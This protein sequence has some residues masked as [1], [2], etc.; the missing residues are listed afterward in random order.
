MVSISSIANKYHLK[1]VDKKTLFEGIQVRGLTDFLNDDDFTIKI[2]NRKKNKSKVD[3]LSINC[4]FDSY[5]HTL[6][7]ISSEEKNILDYKKGL[8]GSSWYG[9]IKNFT[10]AL[11][12]VK[13]MKKSKWTNEGISY[14]S[15][16]DGTKSNKISLHVNTYQGIQSILIR[17]FAEKNP[18]NIICYDAI[19]NKK[20]P[21]KNKLTLY[22]TQDKYLF[23]KELNLTK[24]GL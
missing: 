21:R 14:L 8:Y 12:P 18:Y 4:A 17:G 22:Y 13:S 1:K 2:C 7:K 9:K 16:K 3:N 23:K 11:Y 20:N 19:F 15:L 10:I 5:N 6:Q 24:A